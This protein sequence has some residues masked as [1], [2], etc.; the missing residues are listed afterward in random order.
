MNTLT[1]IDVRISNQGTMWMFTPLTNTAKEW[2]E[3]NLDLESWQKMGDSFAVDHR[4]AA[5]LAEGMQEAGLI[6]V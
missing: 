4:P 3:E 1:Q 5:A 6:V 2:V